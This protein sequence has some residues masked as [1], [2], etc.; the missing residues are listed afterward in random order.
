MTELEMES[1]FDRATEAERLLRWAKKA[2]EVCTAWQLNQLAHRCAMYMNLAAVSRGDYTA[3]YMREFE[4]EAQAND[5]RL[6][7]DSEFTPT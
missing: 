3:E 1:R 6:S 4:R 2:T 7:T 5:D